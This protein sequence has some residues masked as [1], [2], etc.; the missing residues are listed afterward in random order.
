MYDR[1]AVF[2]EIGTISLKQILA[3]FQSQFRIARAQNLHPISQLVVRS[4]I[5]LSFC[6]VFLPPHLA[7]IESVW[8]RQISIGFRVI[9]CQ[10]IDKRFQCET[11]I[12]VTPH[13]SGVSF[14]GRGGS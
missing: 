13:S 7:E 12:Q 8:F 10:R 3:L 14:W 2:D 6:T 1:I 9:L 5:P 4:D 11:C